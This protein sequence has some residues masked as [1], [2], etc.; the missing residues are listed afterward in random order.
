MTFTRAPYETA[1][2]AALAEL[3]ATDRFE[4]AHDDAR[5][6]LSVM[7]SNRDAESMTGRALVPAG[8]VGYLT[9]NGRALWIAASLNEARELL[10]TNPAPAGLGFGEAIVRVEA[11]GPEPLYTTFDLVGEEDA[12]E[13]A[14]TR[15]TSEVPA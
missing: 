5:E 11:T 15:A 4:K 14:W 9:S 6:V 7:N 2:R 1:A 3:D 13:D 10:A 12:D 8:E